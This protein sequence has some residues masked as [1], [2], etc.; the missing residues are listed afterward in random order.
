[1]PP[2]PPASPPQPTGAPQASAVGPQGEAQ[3]N[4]AAPQTPGRS[5]STAQVS[6][7]PPA[8][9]VRVAGGP[10]MVPVFISGASRLSTV[11]IAV[12]FNPA[13]LR[14]RTVQEGSFLRQGAAPVTFTNKVDATLGRIDLTFVRTADAVG[15]SGS[16]L[17]AGIMFDAVGSGTS[18]LNVSGVAADPGGSSVAMQFTPVSVVVR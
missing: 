16:G 2:Q 4:L 17:L 7:T 14:V 9:D 1:M 6:V 10:Y 18:Q 5:T 11:T 8:G 13:V 3:I 12:S 15:A